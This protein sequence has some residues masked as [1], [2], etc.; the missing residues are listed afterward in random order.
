MTKVTT[1]PP[2]EEERIIDSVSQ[3]SVVAEMG[4]QD[5]TEDISIDP[6]VLASVVG[7]DPDPMFVTIQVL[8]E[9][10]SSGNSKRFYPRETVLDICRQINEE[11]PE[12]YAGHLSEA[13]R[14]T[15]VPDTETIWLGA[16]A[17]EVNGRMTVFA[18]G[19]VLPE[20]KNR[21]SVLKRA[22]AIGRKVAVSIYGECTQRWDAA[23]K[24]FQMLDYDLETIDWTRG[25]KSAGFPNQG[26]FVL[27]PEMSE[28]KV[29]MNKIE[30]LQTATAEELR[31]HVA[32]EVVAEMIA[33]DEAL[34]ADRTVASEMRETFGGKDAKEVVAEMAEL[35]SKTESL[36]AELL[37]RDV[38]A[39]LKQTVKSSAA[40]SFLKRSVVAEMREDADL[41]PQA[42]VEKVL[43][44][45]EGKAVVAEM[46]TPI[47]P[48]VT[49]GI[50]RT[51]AVSTS[52][53][54]KKKGQ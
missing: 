20:A 46:V 40:R 22:K 43:K 25:N 34:Q 21:R 38:D 2:V 5:T 14:M 7:D 17:K 44:S 26:D 15:K 32:P 39:E 52:K 16:I 31:E 37:D 3:V 54:I 9:G 23:K 45:D 10:K 18:K 4:G 29:D 28:R 50:D 35:R 53:Y 42:A 1:Q 51:A 49:P 36:A 27:S 8:Q 24:H 12:G 48:T 33:A 30:A 13:E 6:A 41:T 47:E 19:Y 11:K